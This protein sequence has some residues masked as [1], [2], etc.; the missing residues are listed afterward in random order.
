MNRR[1]AVRAIVGG[2][3]AGLLVPQDALTRIA[4]LT[5][6]PTLG[7]L[8]GMQSTQLLS[9]SADTYA[10]WLPN[11]MVALYSATGGYKATGRVLNFEGTTLTVDWTLSA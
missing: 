3:L 8:E 2:V 6:A 1:D 9:L 7:L 5:P 10:R 4:S 11:Q